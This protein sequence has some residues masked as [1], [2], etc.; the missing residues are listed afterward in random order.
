MKTLILVSAVLFI[1][2]SQVN[3]ESKD[4][5]YESRPVRHGVIPVD[6]FSVESKKNEVQKYE[7][8]AIARG[9]VLYENHCLQCHGTSGVGDGEK[10]KELKIKPANLQSTVK[11][12]SNFKFFMSISEWKG[13]MPG[14]S[15]PLSEKQRDDLVAY[16]KTLK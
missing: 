15:T 12:V 2:C 7:P 5:Y 16:I 10:A 1:S 14:W 11:A 6:G 3:R 4:Y 9:K 13:T 8:E